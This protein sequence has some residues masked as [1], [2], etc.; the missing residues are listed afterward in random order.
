MA[1]VTLPRP[2]RLWLPV[3]V[4]ALLIFTFSSIP[5][6]SSGLGTADTVLRKAAHMCEYA[7]L[8]VLLFRALGDELLAFFGTL[9]YA[10]SDELHQTFVRGRH[11]SPV[12]AGIDAIGAFVGLTVWI[13]ETR[14]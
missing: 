6:L 5:S 12:D 10:A 8:A 9:L 3:V 7:M 2:V 13:R 4:W 1:P 14:R 11:G